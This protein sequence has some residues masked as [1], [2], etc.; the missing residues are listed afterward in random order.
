MG[1]GQARSQDSMSVAYHQSQSMNMKT[2]GRFVTGITVCLVI[3]LCVS[4]R[5]GAPFS[6]DPANS[7]APASG[8]YFSTYRKW[9]TSIVE[10]EK[11][12][13]QYEL[14]P[15]SKAQDALFSP[16]PD[17]TLWIIWINPD[18]SQA[19]LHLRSAPYGQVTI[20]DKK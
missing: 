20:L 10:V 13:T 15:I 8:R 5:Q 16:Q 1:W 3:P 6:Q 19:R 2:L 11:G 12:A 7:L 4:C 14:D 17:G 9:P 18:G